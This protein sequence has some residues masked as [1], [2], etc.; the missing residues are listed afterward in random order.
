[1]LQVADVSERTGQ[2]QQDAHLQPVLKWLEMGQRPPRDDV[3]ELFVATK[4]LWAKLEM[5]RLKKG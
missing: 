3:T 4:G 2:L 5:S 1:M